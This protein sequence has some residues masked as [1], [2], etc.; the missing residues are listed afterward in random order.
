MENSFSILFL[1]P[2]AK[3]AGEYVNDLKLSYSWPLPVQSWIP[4]KETIK[5]HYGKSEL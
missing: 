4:D 2:T 3:Q 1:Y 5:T